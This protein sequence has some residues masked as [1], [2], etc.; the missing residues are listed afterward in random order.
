MDKKSSVIGYVC[1]FGETRR[2]LDNCTKLLGQMLQLYA[3]NNTIFKVL[4]GNHKPPTEWSHYG[5]AKKLY[6]FA[7]NEIESLEMI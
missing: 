3:T 5:M 4:K 1:L 7:Y 2:R 6:T